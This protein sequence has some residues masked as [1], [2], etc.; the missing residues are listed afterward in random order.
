MNS[1]TTKLLKILGTSL[2][3]V[4]MISASAFAI[5]H[6]SNNAIQ[7]EA[8]THT[9][10]YASYTYSGTYYNGISSSATEGM[11]GSLRTSLTS[12]IHP[13]SVPVYSSSGATHLSTVLQY[14]DEDP[15][16]SSNMIYLYTRNSVTKNAASTWNRE[17]VWPQSLS[18]SCWG[19]SRAGT[20]LL[21]LRPTYN[22]TNSTRGNLK[23]GEITSGSAVTYEGMPYGYTTGTYF[24]PL[25]S[26]K[27]DVARIIM[28]VWVAYY[29][30]Y[31]SKL[32]DITNVFQSFDV[33]MQ[34]HTNDKPDVMEGNR[35]N[36][37]QNQSMQKNRNPFVDHPEY[38]WKIFGSKCSS[39]VLAAAKA[40]YPADG[41]DTPTPTPTTVTIST[42]SSSLT[43]GNTL[44][45]T[46]TSSDSSTIT[47]TTSNSSVASINKSSTSSGGSIT[48]TAN[49][50]GSATITAK[51]TSNVTATCAVTV[52]ESGGGGGGEDPD[53]IDLSKGVF[54]TDHITWT[55]GS[56][57]ITQTKGNSGTA[58]NSSYI[59]APRIYKGHILSFV[60][61][62]SKI[63]SISLTYDGTYYGDSMTAGTTVVDNV[64]TNN[65]S[66]VARTW[67]TANKGTHIV[68]SVSSSGLSTIHIQ[69][70]A[71][72]NNVQFRP[73]AI[74][75]AFVE[76]AETLESISVSGATTSYYV[77]DTFNFNGTVTATY[78]KG[79]EKV[80]TP[81]Y[82]SSP[83]M[84][85]S[86]NKIVT[87]SYTEDEKTVSD[88]YQINVQEVV[89]SNIVIT[90]TATKTSYYTGDSFDSTGLTVTAYYN[91]ST[92]EVVTEEVTWSP[93]PLEKGTTQ[94]TA[95][96]QGATATYSGITVV[97][98]ELSS[99]SIEGQTTSYVVGSEFSFDGSVLAHYANGNKRY[100][101]PTSVDD[102]NVNMSQRGT[103]TVKVSYTEGGSTMSVSYTIN[104]TSTEFSNS[105]E[106]CYSLADEA[107]VTHD[108]Y[109]LYVGASNGQTIIMNGEY[110][111]M[112]YGKS[113]E[114]SWTENQ[115]YLKVV[116]N[117][118]KVDIYNN[119]YELKKASSNM[120]ITVLDSS[121][122]EDLVE[123]QEN[124]APVSIYT[125]TG[126]ES[127]S[128]LTVANRLC[129][130]TGIVTSITHGS[131]SGY[132]IGSD[133]TVMVDVNGTQIKLFVKA[134]S[135][136]EDV[137]TALNKSLNQS[138]EISV[139]G[140]S[141]F[142]STKFEMQFKNVVEPDPDYTA[143]M[144]AT[145]LLNATN[146]ICASS[147]S[148]ENA[149][150]GVW[151]TFEMDKW[152]TL[153]LEER[154]T[155]KAA[156]A[157]E[158]GT[159]IEQAMARYDQICKKYARCDN[160]IGRAS[161]NN[162]NINLFHIGT[163]NQIV[164]IS[165]I[166]AFISL[167]AFAGYLI[168]RRKKRS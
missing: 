151:I 115:T 39:S 27:G 22:K 49:A 124:I 16:N 137:G 161:A 128:D 98:A 66:A 43:V 153:S 15:T 108:V 84:S 142:Y 25:D 2:L 100:V 1:K 71:S 145:E 165:I 50:A 69:N 42:S 99:I 129:L 14:A 6:L 52:T 3:S 120:Q 57:T 140:Y 26:V 104:V 28:Y 97:D 89:V 155:L 133:N 132:S 35:N 68:S 125:I 60:S 77:G 41:G 86:G 154:A 78:S 87:V 80:V 19:T 131:E 82:I 114:N 112:L 7:A 96:Y 17:H 47:W 53:A 91:N 81:T 88:T 44:N 162:A 4:G 24:M 72:D 126:N 65:T 9:D 122:A 56:L 83:D 13:S 36:Y 101:E 64:V 76:E 58:V 37:A 127:T 121:D 119:L 54:S 143:E 138:K 160:F 158:S 21:H 144:F 147:G 95:T 110:G 116:A 59:S 150:A 92:H 20:D 164:T 79:T 34:W 75:I 30:E 113:P 103:Y 85:T 105:I 32:P 141:S 152:S 12:L 163:S 139:K 55:F 168:I 33:L 136:N 109:G 146:T 31:G 156:N 102:S 67:S 94:V 148:K 8:A 134:A 106:Q 51:N 23:Y 63:A 167:S 93:N 107:T 159:I 61:T 74:S 18:N 118:A 123:I 40:A 29:D 11:T 46:A 135:A 62:G 73:T 149:L 45:L 90:G 130:L 10:N 70:V 5:S 111:I 166:A 48:V 157:D 117:T 38:A